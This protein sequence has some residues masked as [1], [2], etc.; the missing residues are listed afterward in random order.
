MIRP[1]IKNSQERSCINKI[2]ASDSSKEVLPFDIVLLDWTCNTLSFLLPLCQSSILSVC[3]SC[4]SAFVHSRNSFPS[5]PTLYRVLQRLPLLA[6]IVLLSFWAWWKLCVYSC[7]LSKKKKNILSSLFPKSSWN[8]QTTSAHGLN[9]KSWNSSRFPTLFTL[10]RVQRTALCKFCLISF[11][12]TR[13]I[14]KGF[15]SR[16]NSSELIILVFSEINLSENILRWKKF[17]VRYTRRKI[18][19]WSS[20]KHKDWGKTNM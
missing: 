9:S 7:P 17:V 6:A 20:N 15:E 13:Q 8:P 2:C 10:P 1:R 5:F 18:R 3:P 16:I 14:Q 11:N 12:N 19:K 4:V